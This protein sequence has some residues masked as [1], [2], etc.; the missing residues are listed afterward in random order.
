VTIGRLDDDHGGRLLDAWLDDAR[1]QLTPD[2]RRD[3]LTRFAVTGLPLFLK[4]AFEE[5]RQWRSW[6]PPPAAGSRS[7]T[8][9]A[10]IAATLAPE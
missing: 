4:V 3:V 2:Q 10:T 8:A 1:R 7:G 6:D 9:A 5:A